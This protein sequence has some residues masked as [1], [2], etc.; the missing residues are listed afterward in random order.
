MGLF[1]TAFLPLPFQR[2]NQS[3]IYSPTNPTLSWEESVYADHYEYCID[4]VDNDLCDS[5]W[6]PLSTTSVTLNG[7][8]NKTLY[9]W[10]VRAVNNEGS[11]EANKGV[12]DFLN[13]R[14]QVFADVPIDDSMWEYIDTIYSSG[15]TTG[16]GVNPLIFCPMRSVT[17]AA[18]AVFFLRAE[19]GGAYSPPPASHYFA[20][21]PV[22][23]KEWQEAWVDQAYREG[24]TGGCGVNPRRFCPENV[25]TRA[26]MAVFTLRAKYGSGYTPPPASHFYYDMPVPGK[27]WMEPWV[28]EIYRE[29]IDSQCSSEG[30]LFCPEEPSTRYAIAAYIYRAFNLGSP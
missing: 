18:A 9:H 19:H 2:N 28:D 30:L 20:D 12:W 7:L 5:T 22:A 26:A 10:Q 3:G 23:G 1:S 16:C 15:I 25:L 6:I 21:L 4:T 27:E 8:E 17:R 29:E 14:R 24:I 13:V 11:V